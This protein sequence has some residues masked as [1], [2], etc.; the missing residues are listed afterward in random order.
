MDKITP[1]PFCGRY[2]LTSEPIEA[3]I[4]FC[5]RAKILER[6]RQKELNRIE[7]LFDQGIEKFN[8]LYRQQV[9][10]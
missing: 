3:H 4:E 9:T 7:K 6:W 10:K 5:R 1:C 2:N 8:N